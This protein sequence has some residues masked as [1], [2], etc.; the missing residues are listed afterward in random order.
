MAQDGSMAW[1]LSRNHIYIESEK[2]QFHKGDLNLL[3]P[4]AHIKFMSFAQPNVYPNMH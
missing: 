2:R 1:S 4:T 3:Y